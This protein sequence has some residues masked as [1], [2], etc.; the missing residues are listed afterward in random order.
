MD[1]EG[2]SA[3]RVCGYGRYSL[4]DRRS[5][6][7]CGA[8]KS[9][10][11]ET[12]TSTGDCISFCGPGT[13][14]LS[15]DVQ[16]CL[17]CSPDT[18]NNFSQQTACFLCPEG[19]Y[20][21]VTGSSV[22]Q[23]SDSGLPPRYLA[24]C[25][26]ICGMQGMSRHRLCMQHWQEQVLIRSRL[27]LAAEFPR[28]L[29]EPPHERPL[30]FETPPQETRHRPPTRSGA[31]LLGRDLRRSRAHGS[32]ASQRSIAGREQRPVRRLS[33]GSTFQPRFP[34]GTPTPPS[35]CVTPRAP[36]SPR[37]TLTAP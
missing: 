35:P 10:P 33:H 6:Q 13:Y 19:R 37:R 2:V 12:S 34:D 30:S 18:F 24:K 16:P 31:M 32:P 21:N 7:E 8:R 20:S 25:K 1:V 17:P 5:Y 26:G 3:C 22:C 36:G 23:E 4:P 15:D 11:M 14:G 28:S 29:A 9:T 27:R